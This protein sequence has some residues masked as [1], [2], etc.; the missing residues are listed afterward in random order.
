MKNKE[1][2]NKIKKEREN[3]F[4]NPYHGIDDLPLTNEQKKCAL[5]WLAQ[6]YRKIILKTIDDDNHCKHYDPLMIEGKTALR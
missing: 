3:N 2:N 1:I 6:K 5:E 4:G